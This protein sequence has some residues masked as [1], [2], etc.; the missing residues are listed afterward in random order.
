M[1]MCPHMVRQISALIHC[2]RCLA[3][4]T[5]LLRRCRVSVWVCVVV[6]VAVQ[7]IQFVP[8]PKRPDEWRYALMAVGPTP[9]SAFTSVLPFPAT[10]TSSF[11]HPSL[12]RF[13][14]RMSEPPRPTASIFPSFTSFSLGD[15]SPADVPDVGLIVICRHSIRERFARPARR[16]IAG[17]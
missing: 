3:K 5:L 6:V 11:C 8:L 13:I 14:P 17:E 10:S 16:T 7:A 15:Y 1:R 2:T 9:T 4:W 12:R